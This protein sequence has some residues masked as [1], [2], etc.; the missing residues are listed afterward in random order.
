MRAV[1]CAERAVHTRRGL[2]TLRLP[3]PSLLYMSSALPALGKHSTRHLHRLHSASR[4]APV[5]GTLQAESQGPCTI[6]CDGAIS[7]SR[8]HS[9]Q[10]QMQRL[11]CLAF[12]Q[13]VALSLRPGNHLLNTS[14][15]A[16]LYSVL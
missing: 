8:G 11:P 7:Q 15:S 16:S 9:N 13:A 6:I 14:G 5:H 3:V 4:V 2:A 10:Y 1:D 12:G